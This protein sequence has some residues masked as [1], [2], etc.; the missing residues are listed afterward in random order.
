MTVNQHEQ[1]QDPENNAAKWNSAI[2]IESQLIQEHSAAQRPIYSPQPNRK[3][4]K[5]SVVFF[6]QLSLSCSDSWMET[7]LVCV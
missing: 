1:Y 7:L 3:D 4:T 6:L 5:F 2:S